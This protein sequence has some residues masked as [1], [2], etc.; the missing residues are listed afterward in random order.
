M[1]WFWIGLGL[2]LSAPAAWLLVV[3]CFFVRWYW[4]YVRHVV[5]I[6]QEKPLFIVPRGQPIAGA[7]EVRFPTSDGLTLAGCYLRRRRAA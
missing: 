5:R 4:C 3:A 7:E 1:V 2:L 6:F